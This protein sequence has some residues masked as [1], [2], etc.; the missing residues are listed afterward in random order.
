MPISS[1]IAKYGKD[2]F[3]IEQICEC[4]SLD[5]LNLKELYYAKLYDTFSPNGYNLRA[6]NGKGSMSQEVKL[7]I[8]LKHKGKKAS[9]ETIEKLRVSHLGHKL[10]AET[11]EKLSIALRGRIIS[12]YTR[13]RTSE[14]SQKTYHFINPIGENT[15]IINMKRF[16]ELH[17]LSKSKMCEV[18]TGKRFQYKGWRLQRKL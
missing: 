4:Y 16:C 10:S 13:Q 2:N 1:A 17:N 7:K 6:G 9:K 3:T 11:K 5:E 15:L 12:E 14:S 18:A 8:G